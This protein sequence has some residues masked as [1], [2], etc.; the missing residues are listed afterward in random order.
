MGRGDEDNNDNNDGD[1]DNN[2]DADDYDDNNDDADDYD[3][4]GNDF[5]LW[6]REI[7]CFQ[8]YTMPTLRMILPCQFMKTR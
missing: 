2:D 8:C 3:D 6:F 5:T 1:N 7:Q 4:T